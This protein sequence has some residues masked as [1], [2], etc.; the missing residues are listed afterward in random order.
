MKSVGIKVISNVG[1]IL[2]LVENA[3]GLNSA[4]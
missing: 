1:A 4:L 2:Q 3:L